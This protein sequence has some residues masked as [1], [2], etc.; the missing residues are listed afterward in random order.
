MRARVAE[1]EA[2]RVHAAGT[3]NSRGRHRWRSIASAILLTLSCVLAPVTIAAVWASTQVSDTDRYVETVSPLIDEPSVQ[4]DLTDAVTEV[5]FTHVDLE[6][7]T[8]EALGA[9]SDLGLAPRAQAALQ[10]LQQPL[11]SGIEDFVHTR[12]AGLISSQQFATVWDQANE[13]AHTQLLNLLEGTQGGAISAQSDT[14]TV[15]LGPIVAQVKERLIADGFDLASNIPEVDVSYELVESDAVTQAQTAYRLLT[16]LSI[17]LPIITLILFVAGVLL[18]RYRSRAVMFG[19]L[20]ILAS[21]LAL[22]I[23]LAV[24]RIVYLQALPGTVLSSESA[25]MVYD[26]L[27]RF[28]RDGLRLVAVLALVVA[29][30]AYFSGSSP[31]A[32]RARAAASRGIAR[33]RG[34]AEGAGMRTGGFGVWVY[35][36][37]RL[38]WVATVIIGGL[39]LVFWSRPTIAV[40]ITT[41]IVVIVVIAL[42]EFL[43]RPPSVPLVEPAED[44][45]LLQQR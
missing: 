7:V 31:S 38:L 5:I 8:D 44:E 3:A 27:V 43:A 26:T 30:A 11:I 12:V 20:G 39:V 41:T 42:I 45:S 34:R 15:N 32:V 36:Y 21:M 2:E 24:A 4:A 37:K 16:A 33:L 19:A 9:V 35:K 13:I 22:G 17:W 18:A 6:A 10:A 29:I 25:G 40:V 14:I 23:A 1:L 28:L